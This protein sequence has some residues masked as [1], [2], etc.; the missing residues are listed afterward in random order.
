MRIFIGVAFSTKTKESLYELQRS[1]LDHAVS[2]KPTLYN[3]IH[4][5]LKFIGELNENE[6]EDLKHSLD[7]HLQNQ[8]SFNIKIGDIGSFIKDDKEIV[9]AGITDGKKTLMALQ[10][11]IVK[12][13]SNA[14]IITKKEKYN[15]HITLAREVLFLDGIHTLPLINTVETIKK[16]TMFRSHRI[17]DILTYTPIYE[18]ELH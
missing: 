9:W 17:K 4:L 7:E 5:T 10:S 1:W 18:F 16:V 3:N 15:P 8:K 14:N 6:I 2:K 12:A 11:V 13:I